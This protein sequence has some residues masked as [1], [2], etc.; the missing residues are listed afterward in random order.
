MSDLQAKETWQR[1]VLTAD[2]VPRAGV[3]VSIGATVVDFEA[4]PLVRDEVR[5]S[6]RCLSLGQLDREKTR[7]RLRS[8]RAA[9]E[10]R[11]QYQRTLRRAWGWPRQAEQPR[12]R[13]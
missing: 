3:R 8:L 6:E 12:R 11:L 5:V 2:V 10:K 4:V 7:V 13:R 1:C 9:R